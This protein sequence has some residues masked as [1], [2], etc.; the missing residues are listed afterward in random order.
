MSRGSLNKPV[1]MNGVFIHPSPGYAATAVE[2]IVLSIHVAV[3]WR[4][5][6][7]GIRLNEFVVSLSN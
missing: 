5:R 7:T 6:T 2:K 1:H 3:C 4:M